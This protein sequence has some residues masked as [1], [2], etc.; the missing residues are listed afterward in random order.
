MQE[1]RFPTPD[2]L[3]KITETVARIG[4]K[5]VVV[6]EKHGILNHQLTV[7]E[8]EASERKLDELTLAFMQHKIDV[9][10][11][12]AETDKLPRLDLRRVAD[13]SR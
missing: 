11:Y 12:R 6:L 8:L 9:D 3:S 10:E 2:K 7:E 5:A 1:R 4:Q 13:L